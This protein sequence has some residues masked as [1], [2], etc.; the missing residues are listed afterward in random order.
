MEVNEFYI[1]YD[2]EPTCSLIKDVCKCKTYV[3]THCL[4]KYIKRCGF[5]CSV[6]REDFICSYNEDYN[7]VHF[8]FHGEFFKP[9]INGALPNRPTSIEHHIG[10]RFQ[11]RILVSDNIYDK[12]HY[13]IV[14]NCPKYL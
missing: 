9:L 2:K 6:C 1:C 13:A 8:P 5:K 10:E 11:G 12:F 3:H 14:N 4:R 7:L